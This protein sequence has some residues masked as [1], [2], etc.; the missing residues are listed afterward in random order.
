MVSENFGRSII[1]GGQDQYYQSRQLDSSAQNTDQDLQTGIP[2]LYYCHNVMPHDQGYQSIGY[3]QILAPVPGA[4]DFKER[5]ILRDSS[6]NKRILGIRGNGDFW[7]NDGT[8]WVF[9]QANPVGK[10]V[11]TAYI[12][13]ITYVFVAGT[14]CYKYDF[15]TNT[16]GV[17]A[18]TGLTLA[19]VLGITGSFGYMIAWTKDTVVWSSTVDP[20]DFTPSLVTGAGGG[21]VEGARG[22]INCCV[23]HTL[24]YVV[25]TQANAVVA[26]FSDN[27]R[28]PFRYREIVNSGGV[29]SI[30]LVTWDA[31]TPSHYVYSTSGVQQVSTQQ[32]QT[33]FPEVTDFI[34]GRFFED[35]DDATQTFVTQILSA[36]MAKKIAMVC[37]RYLVFS[38]G[39][40]ELTH[41]I[42]W[43]IALKRYGKLKF[44]HVDIFEYELIA[45]G[46]VE[47][48]RQSFAL[49]RKDGSVYVIDFALKSLNS[50]GT[51]IFGKYQYVRSRLIQMDEVVFENIIP[52][53]SFSLTILPA[54]DGK[55]TVNETPNLIDSSGTYR[56]YGCRSIGTNISLLA[57]GGWV[58]NTIVLK[59][60]V[61]GKR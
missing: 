13:G 4:G 2:Q 53:N 9:K 46:I 38:Y 6:D 37:D 58:I 7:V 28:Y 27:A 3:T 20:T 22:S 30:D 50:N 49:L 16:F 52:N 57:Q 17:V 25:Y 34:S 56:K 44:T 40:T 26:L 8:G 23:A 36:G 29:A 45:P 51:A 18:L 19:N 54:I 33:V 60:N 12:S 5:H 15:G 14:G 55:N 1:V 59:F 32:T 31:N 42:V 39:V 43:D 10:A 48:P 11:T 21:G 41:A 61:H 35:F 47:I 24:G